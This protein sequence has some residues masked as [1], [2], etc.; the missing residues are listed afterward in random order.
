MM[1]MRPEEKVS[2]HAFREECDESVRRI[3]IEAI[4]FNPRIP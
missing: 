3:E 4:S 2:I 1:A